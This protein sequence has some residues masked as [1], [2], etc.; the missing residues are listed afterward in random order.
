MIEDPREV[1]RRRLLGIE[2]SEGPTREDLVEALE[3]VSFSSIILIFRT[4]LEMLKAIEI[5]QILFG[6]NV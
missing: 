6:L 4:V 1:E 5:L 2:Y 3:E